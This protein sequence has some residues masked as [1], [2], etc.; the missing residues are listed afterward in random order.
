MGGNDTEL[1]QWTLVE[2]DERGRP[3]VVGKETTVHVRPGAVS[4]AAAG[5]VWEEGKVVLPKG[6]WSYAVV[7]KGGRAELAVGRTC[8]ENGVEAWPKFYD[9]DNLPNDE[10]SIDDLRDLGFS[11]VK[12]GS[13][14]SI[15]LPLT[16]RLRIASV[17]ATTVE[18][19]QIL[20]KELLSPDE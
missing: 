3:N 5:L 15:E 7:F 14:T 8:H 11:V 6:L 1:R 17:P 12:I 16:P 2:V 4:E 10:V 19:D 20:R 9:I 13:R 18:S